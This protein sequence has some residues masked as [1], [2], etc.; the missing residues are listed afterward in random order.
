MKQFLITSLF[1]VF[2]SFIAFTSQGQITPSFSTGSYHIE[3]NESLTT[4]EVNATIDE[5]KHMIEQL[6]NCGSYIHADY[7]KTEGGYMVTLKIQDQTGPEYVAKLMMVLGF[8]NY[9]W[10]N[11]LKTIDLLESDLTKK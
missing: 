3:K 5:V 8:S 7:A 11:E 10:N 9:T 6:Q 1:A 4:F 2:F